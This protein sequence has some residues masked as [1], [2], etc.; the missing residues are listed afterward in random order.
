MLPIFSSMC[1]PMFRITYPKIAAR[2]IE[3]QP[4]SQPSWLLPR[5]CTHS[6]HMTEILILFLLYSDIFSMHQPHLSV[7]LD[8]LIISPGVFIEL[9]HT[10]LET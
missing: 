9:D 10:P 4:G 1:S 8:V 6:V 2:G 7:F 5:V 3:T